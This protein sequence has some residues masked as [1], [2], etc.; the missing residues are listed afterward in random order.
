MFIVPVIPS[1]IKHVK[2]EKNIY[3]NNVIMKY[4]VLFN[5]DKTALNNKTI[6]IVFNILCKTNQIGI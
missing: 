6:Y 5:Q 3:Y 1:L 4:K 2:G